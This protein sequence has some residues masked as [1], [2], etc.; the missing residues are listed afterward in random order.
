MT[1]RGWTWTAS[2]ALA[3]A[4]AACGSDEPVAFEPTP[5]TEPSTPGPGG[6]RRLTATQYVNTVRLLFGDA[7][8]AAATPPADHA[9]SGLD[10]IGASE[11]AVSDLQVE[12]YEASAM[13]VAN[14]F[15]A[16]PAAYPATLP[17][18][19]TGTTDTACFRDYVA[20]VGRW[21]W[22]RPLSED[23]IAGLVALA[24]DAASVH[25]SFEQGIVYATGNL[26]QSPH[27]TYQVEVGEPTEDPGVRRLTAEELATRM[28]FV[29]LDRGPDPVLLDA[30][31]DGELDS[32]EGRRQ[33]AQAMLA[34]AE[35]RQAFATFIR[36]LWRLRDLP[37]TAKNTDTF[38]EWTP[39]VALSAEE[40][41]LRL[42]E[43]VVWEQREDF[44]AVLTSRESFV[45]E[46]LAPLYGLPAPAPGTWERVT[47]PDAQGRSGLLGTVAFLARQAHPGDSSPTRRG[48]FIQDRLRCI[49]IPPPPPDVETSLPEVPEGEALTKKELLAATHQEEACASCH[50]HVDPLGLAL[51]T[52]DAIGRHR[53]TDAGKTIDT[54]GEVPGIGA[55][56]DGRAVGELLADDPRVSACLVQS[57]YRDA[58]GHLESEGEQPALDE[59]TARFAEADHRVH[60]LLLEL[61]THPIFR[62][63]GEPK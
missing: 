33:I 17:C 12:R 63:V 50:E 48:L 29:L 51:E 5:A 57:L 54:A 11:L 62:L 31:A 25:D 13:A 59:L 9:L 44:R 43:D 16:D 26:L 24:E 22:R 14:A 23:E 36:E 21:A 45:D 32:D 4:L 41:V 3:V 46:H 55:F 15:V 27:F 2:I 6:L 28:A 34:T 30:A 60:A 38:P 7:A 10:A 1:G 18:V 37:E 35:A 61:V 52:F 19:P 20:M 39:A 42:V 40:E 56:A 8:A 47:L 58:V 53:T 49:L